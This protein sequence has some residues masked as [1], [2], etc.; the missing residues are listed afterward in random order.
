MTPCMLRAEMRHLK[1][2][3]RSTP[4]TQHPDSGPGSLAFRNGHGETLLVLAAVDWVAVGSIATVVVAIAT[5]ALVVATRS[6]R[7]SGHEGSYETEAPRVAGEDILSGAPGQASGSDGY[8]LKIDRDGHFMGGDH[9]ATDAV[10]A[11]LNEPTGKRRIRIHA[12]VLDDEEYRRA[13]PGL[14]ISLRRHVA[15]YEQAVNV[16]VN[17]G[18]HYQEKWTVEDL[19]QAVLELRSL[20]LPARRDGERWFSWPSSDPADLLVL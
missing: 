16:L 7:T 17:G 18:V 20:A 13:R 8:S 6:D 3:T 10:V 19:A 9:Q 2:G 5:V 4:R 12:T 11:V 15:L 1:R 14:Y